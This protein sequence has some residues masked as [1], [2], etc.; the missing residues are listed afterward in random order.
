[1]LILQDLDSNYIH[2]VIEKYYSKYFIYILIL[3]DLGYEKLLNMKPIKSIE[4]IKI[5]NPLEI[6]KFNY[7]E[8]KRKAN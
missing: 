1:F 3:N 7:E 6:R 4:S 5:L 2:K 8:F